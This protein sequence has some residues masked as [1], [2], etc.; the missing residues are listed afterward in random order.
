MPDKED[1]EL[2]L[3]F[4]CRVKSSE[5]EL[6]LAGVL[7][8]KGLA[9][10]P[11]CDDPSNRTVFSALLRVVCKGWVAFVGELARFLSVEEAVLCPV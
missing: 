11:I 1:K 10:T 6:C 4:L 5:D 7:A 3:A 2:S 8:R 9:S